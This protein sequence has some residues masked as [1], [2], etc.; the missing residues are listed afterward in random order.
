METPPPIRVCGSP[1]ATDD[2]IRITE[3]YEEPTKL[4]FQVIR[5]EIRRLENELKTA[6]F[7]YP[8]RIAIKQYRDILL[9]M[10]AIKQAY[11]RVGKNKAPELSPDCCSYGC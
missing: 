1:K 8:K 5:F 6:M 4:D 11:Y 2:E 10:Y 7:K 9:D 3:R